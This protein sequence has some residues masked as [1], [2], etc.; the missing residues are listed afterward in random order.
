MTF[1][2]KGVVIDIGSGSDYDK[3]SAYTPCV[4]YRGGLYRCYYTG[5][6][7]TNQRVMLAVSPDGFTWTK[8][9]VVIDIGTDPDYD[10]HH[11]YTPSVIYRDGLYRCYYGGYDGTTYRILLAVSPDGF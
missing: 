10:H 1:T 9:G 6:N 3:T 7:G 5:N 2:K 11:A 8:K 4:I